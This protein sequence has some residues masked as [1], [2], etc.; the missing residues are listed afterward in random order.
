MTKKTFVSTKKYK[1]MFNAS[2]LKTCCI[3]PPITYYRTACT[4][5]SLV[6]SPIQSYSQNTVSLH[7]DDIISY[8]YKE[9]LSISNQPLSDTVSCID[10]TVHL[11][12][13][14]IEEAR[15]YYVQ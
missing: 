4:T 5:L 10:H 2:I 14:Q 8:I 6:Q 7:T 9:L 3:V 12:K 13:Q 11:K 15:K 1:A